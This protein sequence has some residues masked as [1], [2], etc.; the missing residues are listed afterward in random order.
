MLDSLDWDDDEVTRCR[1]TALVPLVPFNPRIRIIGQTPPPSD[2][3][4]LS[5]PSNGE[6]AER[7]DEEPA[8]TT[9]DFYGDGTPAFDERETTERRAV[10]PPSSAP[11]VDS[12]TAV[13]VARIVNVEGPAPPRW[14]DVTVPRHARELRQ[15]AKRLAALWK[16][17]QASKR[18]RD[19]PD[20]VTDPVIEAV[21]VVD[22][23][24]RDTLVELDSPSAAASA[25]REPKPAEGG[26]PPAATKGDDLPVTLPRDSSFP[27]SVEVDLSGLDP[28]ADTSPPSRLATSGDES[29]PASEEP[30]PKPATDWRP[31]EEHV[32]AT[33]PPAGRRPG[34]LRH[35]SMPPVTMSSPSPGGGPRRRGLAIAALGVMLIL[36]STIFALWLLPKKGGLIVRLRTADGHPAAKAEIFVDGQKRC[37]TD[38]CVIEGLSRGDRTVKVI[39]PGSDEPHVASVTLRSGQT[40]TVWIDVP[41]RVEEVTESPEPVPVEPLLTLQLKTPGARV[42]IVPDGEVGRVI[43]G[44]FPRTIGL[45]L[46][47]Y[48]VVASLHGYV[49]FV[50]RVTLTEEAPS[51]SV[52]VELFARAT[53]VREGGRLPDDAPADDRTEAPKAPAPAA[54]PSD[55]AHWDPYADVEW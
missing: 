2:P 3:E 13:A 44:P 5:G 7:T 9:R 41:S 54:V 45:P 46:G 18:K 37:D 19:D 32:V 34:E 28:F 47:R 29:A 36:C 55:A 50:D 6:A 1:G 53:P 49:P 8:P 24:G 26:A 42:V 38:P 22:V 17:D 51:A 4:E 15:R 21:P 11:A 10:V 31:L 16:Q 30:F 20:S 27:P 35:S 40:E 39:V 14:D 33:A 52:D 23:A 25:D 12:S 48:E 43:Q